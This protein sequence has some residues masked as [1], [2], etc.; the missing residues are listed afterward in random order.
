MK[1][2]I[3]DIG[4]V[5]DFIDFTFAN[6]ITFRP[7]KIA[8]TDRCSDVYQWAKDNVPEESFLE[9]LHNYLDDYEKIMTLPHG[10]CIYDVNGTAVCLSD[11]L[12]KSPDD[13]G[14]LRQLILYGN[15]RLTYDWQY[16]AAQLL[17]PENK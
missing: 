13:T 2:G 16:R 12:T 1:N 5:Q 6:Q 3:N 14:R 17:P 15:G 9:E 11:C 8:D 10:A 7:M 4:K